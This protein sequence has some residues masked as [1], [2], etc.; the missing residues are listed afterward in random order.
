MLVTFADD[1]PGIPEQDLPRIFERFYKGK[2]GGSGL[3]LAITKA[4]VEKSA[5]SISVENCPAGGAVFTVNLPL[6]L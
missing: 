3:G 1:G 2:G 4:I 5:G 6:A